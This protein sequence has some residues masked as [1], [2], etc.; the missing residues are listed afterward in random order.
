M[1]KGLQYKAFTKVENIFVNIKTLNRLG[2]NMTV[3]TTEMSSIL[4]R[5]QRLWQQHARQIFVSCDLAFVGK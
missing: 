4:K 5:L 1:A 2:T 3:I